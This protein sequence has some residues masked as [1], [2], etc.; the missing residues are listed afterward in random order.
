MLVKQ[1]TGL[2]E[3]IEEKHVFVLKNGVQYK[4]CW[5]LININQNKYN[6]HKIPAIVTTIMMK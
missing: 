1:E 5:L 3:E 4:P 6:D 2:F